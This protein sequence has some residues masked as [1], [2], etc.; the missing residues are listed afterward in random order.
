MDLLNHAKAKGCQQRGADG[1]VTTPAFHAKAIAG[2]IMQVADRPGDISILTHI[3]ASD[4]R[5]PDGPGKLI[6]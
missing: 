2:K 1:R 4:N 5:I 3:F 6:P